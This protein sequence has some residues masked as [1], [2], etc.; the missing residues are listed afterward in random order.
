MEARLKIAR[1]GRFYNMLFIEGVQRTSVHSLTNERAED[2]LPDIYGLIK[3]RL[4]KPMGNVLNLQIAIDSSTIEEWSEILKVLIKAAIE[5]TEPNDLDDVSRRRTPIPTTLPP[6]K[7]DYEY[8]QDQ[9]S[10]PHTHVE[11]KPDIQHITKPQSVNI[12]LR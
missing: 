4:V 9:E 8:S 3:D 2:R 7:V 10:P 6:K 1:S 12:R 5:D 11:T